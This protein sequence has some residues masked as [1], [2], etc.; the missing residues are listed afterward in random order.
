MMKKK[1]KKHE[2]LLNN[3]MYNNFLL[4]TYPAEI[5]AF[6]VLYVVGSCVRMVCLLAPILVVVLYVRTY[7]LSNHP[8]SISGNM[9]ACKTKPLY[10]V[11]VLLCIV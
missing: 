3:Q 8:L 4:R 5:N 7:D 10:Y 11:N 1:E 2:V 9:H 6:V